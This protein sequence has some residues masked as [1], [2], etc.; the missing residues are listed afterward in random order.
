M[1]SEDTVTDWRKFR[2]FS[3]IALDH[4]YVLSWHIEQETLVVDVDVLLT[5]E[6]PFFETPRP[7]EKQCIRPAVIE[8]PYCEKVETEEKDVSGLA[9]I[10]ASLS[11]GKIS[12]LSRLED[13]RYEIE[14]EF[15][16]VAVTAERPI[17]R[18]K[19]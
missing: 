8:F 6:H 15:G 10:V 16:R 5:E 11:L 19:N 12:N 2:E 9:S 18:L 7:S 3:A 1:S 17:L 13:G 4:S 14:G